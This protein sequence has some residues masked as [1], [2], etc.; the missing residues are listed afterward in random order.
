MTGRGW[1]G[2]GGERA[3]DEWR[4]ARGKTR[5]T[6]TFHLGLEIPSGFRPFENQKRL[7]PLLG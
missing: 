5:G 2:S 1:I 3:R 6:P 4:V 7:R